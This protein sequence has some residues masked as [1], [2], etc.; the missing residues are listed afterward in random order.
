MMHSLGPR[1][2][3]DVPGRHVP[4][5]HLRCRDRRTCRRKALEISKGWDFHA[6]VVE[7]DPLVIAGVDV[8]QNEWRPVGVSHGGWTV[9]C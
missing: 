7:N 1:Q 3:A 5:A 9:N 6:I 4:P 8:W 2:A